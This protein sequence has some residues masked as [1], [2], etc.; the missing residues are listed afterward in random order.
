M[1]YQAMKNMDEPDAILG[2]GAGSKLG[3]IAPPDSKE[4]FKDIRLLLNV[5]SEQTTNGSEQ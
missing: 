2:R 3:F 4:Y 5:G 1:T